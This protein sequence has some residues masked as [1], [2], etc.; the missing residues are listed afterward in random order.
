MNPLNTNERLFVF[1]NV[2]N[3]L[4]SKSNFLFFSFLR[5]LPHV[6]PFIVHSVISRGSPGNTLLER[7]SFMRGAKYNI[8][9]LI[10][11]LIDVSKTP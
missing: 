1:T 4:T 5:L 3:M 11:S 9:G 8:G 6:S 7:T 2:Y 10:F